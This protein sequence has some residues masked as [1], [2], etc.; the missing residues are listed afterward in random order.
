VINKILIKDLDVNFYLKKKRYIYQK[1]PKF[2]KNQKRISEVFGF[3][4]LK[5][6][7]DLNLEI[8]AGNKVGV[9]GVNG[10]G[11]TTFLKLCSNSIFPSKGK[12]SIKGKINSFLSSTSLVNKNLTGYENAKFRAKINNID[13]VGSFIKKIKE[14]SQLDEF[15]YLPA[16]T[17]SKGM[18]ARLNIN[19][20]SI[21]NN[22]GIF[23]FDEW[24]GNLD[25]FDFNFF[26]E[27]SIFL[28]ASHNLKIL[29]KYC[30]KILWLHKG[31]IWK[32]GDYRKIIHEYEIFLE[33]INK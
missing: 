30:N 32:Y 24:I 17:Y 26:T 18:M 10:S 19:L 22:D 28:L 33:K 8:K 16:K 3:W 25:T 27:K 20:N 2:F 4:E 23:I 5:I 15:F 21:E 29:K 13:D 31:K 7:S 14:K 6:L 12:I 9:I 1:I 11:K